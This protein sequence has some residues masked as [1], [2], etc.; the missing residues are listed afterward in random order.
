MVEVPQKTKPRL[1]LIDGYALIYRAFFAMVSRPLTTT[2]GENTSAAFGFV[3]FLL[4]ILEEH[5]PDYMGVVFDAGSSERKT[6][7]PEYK[8]TREKMPDDLRASLRRIRDLIDAFRIPVI[9]LADHEADDVI[10][11]LAK[12]AAERAIEAVV[13]SGD[14]DFY[15]LIGPNIALLNPGRGGMANVEEEWVDERNASERLGVPPAHVIDYLALIG[16]SSDNVPGAPGIGPK[17]AI[18]LIEQY[19]SVDA[20]LEHAAEIKAKR[21]RE[22]LLASEQAVRMSKV[23]VTIRDDLP[24]D[25]DLGALALREPDRIRLRDLFIDLEFHS[26]ARELGEPEQ[27]SAPAPR[28]YVLADTPALVAEMIAAVR[29]AGRV[30]L[31]VAGSKPDAM[32]GEIV[33]IGLAVEPGRSWYLPFAHRRPGV[34][35]LEGVQTRNLPALDSAE[36]APLAE[37]LA[38]ATVAK[39][40]HDLKH[41]ILML[42]RVGVTLS[43]VSFDTQIASYVIDASRRDHD[44]ASLALQHLKHRRRAAEEV[45]GKGKEEV[46]LGEVEITAARDWIAEAPDLA[47]RLEAIFAKDLG[48][49]NA[50]AL[51]RDI[52]MPLLDV[53]VGMETAGIRIDSEFFRKQQVKLARELKLIEEDIYRVAG[54]PFNINSTPQLRTILFDKLG[55]PVSRRTKTGASTDASVL[56]ELAATGHQ[57]PKLIL[58]FRQLDKLKGTYVDSLPLQV[59]PATGRIHSSFSQTVAATGRLSSSDPN[60]QNV[61]IRTQTGAELRKG[62]VP[63]DGF[64]FLGADYSQIELRILAHMSADP[65]I[66]DAFRKGV[67]VH[68]QTAALVFGVDINAVTADMRAAAKTVNFAT[69]YGIGPFALSQQL[70]TS[71]ADARTFIE[72]YFARLPRVR[73]Y[74]DEQIEKARKLGYV[75]TLSGRRRYIP[76]VH[77]KNWNI[78]QFGERAATN[79]PVQ[80][81]AADIIKIAMIRIHQAFRDRK[82][83]ARMLLQVHDELVFEVPAADIEETRSLVQRLMQDA[84][85]LDVPL[86]V[87]TGIGAT[88]FDC[89]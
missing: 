60:L 78:R 66:G 44:L 12:K 21:A 1:F 56:E 13:V 88:W 4:K 3:R 63:A 43:G 17:T 76:E 57:L 16:D 61:P 75:E 48:H 77:A 23:L 33:G 73:Q 59:N 47:L 52:E 15:Q 7:Y 87:A 36:M 79:A 27:V 22:A 67:D 82:S 5:S 19:G 40:G 30:A 54:E 51:F 49:A 35:D 46:P 62:F 71:V 9:E 11:T 55:L 6:M 58:E 45:R 39:I 18:Q 64:L 24:V 68:R 28:Q 10:G 2:K 81:T 83:R 53:L 41:S 50:E 29:K 65:V 42:R 20:I 25:L 37:L 72:N 89:K 86:Q 74:L 38:D 34:L 14:K 69:I 70:G 80:G 8:A 26:L 84:F 32:R 85:P 31:E